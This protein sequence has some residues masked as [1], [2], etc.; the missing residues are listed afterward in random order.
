[1]KR[2]VQCIAAAIPGIITTIITIIIKKIL[3]GEPERIFVIEPL[4]RPK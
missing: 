3:S 1:M 2:N 4:C